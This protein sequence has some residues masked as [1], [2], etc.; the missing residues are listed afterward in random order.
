MGFK[1]IF[2]LEWKKIWISNYLNFIKDLPETSTDFGQDSG[3]RHCAAAK[4]WIASAN[5]AGAEPT[6]GERHADILWI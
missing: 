4:N 6:L 3:I 5:V 1:Q 2:S